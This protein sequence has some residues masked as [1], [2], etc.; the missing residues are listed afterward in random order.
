MVA[1]DGEDFT[2]AEVKFKARNFVV[3]RDLLEHYDDL[4]Y[5]VTIQKEHCIIS[6]KDR[7]SFLFLD[8]VSGDLWG[9]G[10]VVI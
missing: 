10:K 4:I 1:V 2:F 9:V 5:L 7:G 3:F 6:K 8:F